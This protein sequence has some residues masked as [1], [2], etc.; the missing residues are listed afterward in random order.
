M[1]QREKE[2]SESCDERQRRQGDRGG[3]VWGGEGTVGRGEKG[4][5]CPGA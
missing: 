5:S 2:Q 4:R 3:G 1:R